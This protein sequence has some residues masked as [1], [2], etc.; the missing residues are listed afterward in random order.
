MARGRLQA[1]PWPGTSAIPSPYNTLSPPTHRAATKRSV[2]LSQLAHTGAWPPI[3]LLTCGLGGGK[4]AAAAPR[5]S[6]PPPP[7]TPPH[8]T[9]NRSTQKYG[10]LSSQVLQL[11]VVLANGT[12]ATVSPDS[13]PHLFRALGVSV[14]RLGVLTELK[15][16]IKPQARRERARAES[17]G[18][19]Y[20]WLLPACL[21]PPHSCHPFT[22]RWQ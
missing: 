17:A 18:G 6:S 11:T 7:L 20:L 8:P 4:Q 9:L 12:M 5:R 22:C 15:L 13:N 2:E 10:S 16:R 19:C 3:S 21:P 14:G 1:P